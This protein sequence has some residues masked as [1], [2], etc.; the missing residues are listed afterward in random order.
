MNVWKPIALCAVA[1]TVLSVGV[2]AYAAGKSEPTPSVAGG[3]CHG[4]PN[5][6]HA[7]ADLKVARASLE[8]AE[9]DKGGWRTAAIQSIDN[10]IKETDRGC[11]F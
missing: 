9:H 8:R 5:M 6:A 7:A 1:A 4:Q 11:A 3:E 10:A 2:Q